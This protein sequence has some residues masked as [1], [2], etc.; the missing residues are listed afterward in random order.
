VII[1]AI[2]RRFGLVDIGHSGLEE[3]TKI[4]GQE[5]GSRSAVSLMYEFL[6]VPPYLTN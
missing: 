4:T 5:A 2:D 6:F 1:F 3:N